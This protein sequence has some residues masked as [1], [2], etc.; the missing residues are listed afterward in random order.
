MEIIVI[1]GEEYTKIAT[2]SAVLFSDK[3]IM[4]NAPPRFVFKSI[5][6]LLKHIRRTASQPR[7]DIFLGK[8]FMA[9]IDNNNED[10]GEG[11]G[12]DGIKKDI[13]EVIRRMTE[14][15]EEQKAQEG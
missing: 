5:A 6:N 10:E 7:F 9:I 8:L 3:S 14:A 2:E 4:V 12:E 11:E 15:L 13:M 1:D